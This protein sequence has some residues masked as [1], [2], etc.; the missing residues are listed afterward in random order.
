MKQRGGDPGA[1]GADRVV[2]HRSRGSHES[3]SGREENG[4]YW[5]FSEN[6]LPVIKEEAQKVEIK[7]VR[8]V[9]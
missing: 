7:E 3:I 1:G 8:I 6:Y 4:A 9:A 2:G 5:L